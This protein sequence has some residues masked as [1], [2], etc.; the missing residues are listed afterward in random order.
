LGKNDG[1]VLVKA[2]VATSADEKT[3]KKESDSLMVLDESRYRYRYC[4]IDD[5]V[6]DE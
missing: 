5:G 3:S 4:M 6:M 2:L 1:G